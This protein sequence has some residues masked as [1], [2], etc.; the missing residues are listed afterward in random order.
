MIATQNLPNLK[1]C[2]PAKWPGKSK[3]TTTIWFLKRSLVCLFLQVINRKKTKVSILRSNWLIQLKVPIMMAKVEKLLLW[4]SLKV[5][6]KGCMLNS[7]WREWFVSGDEWRDPGCHDEVTPRDAP[8]WQLPTAPRPR[9]EH[10]HQ[11][12]NDLLDTVPNPKQNEY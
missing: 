3:M 5:K 11:L 6:L 4:V 12:R 7:Q 2:P 8:P 10:P 9:H 1:H